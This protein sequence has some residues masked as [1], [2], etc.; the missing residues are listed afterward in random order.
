MDLSIII[1]N[2]N[3]RDFLLKCVQSVF[4]STDNLLYEVIVV[5]NASSDGSQA[6]IRGRFPQVRMIENVENVGFVR[7]NNQA[8]STCRGRYVLLLNSDAEAT[9]GSLSELVYFMDRHPAAAVVGPRLVNPDFS[10]QASHTPFPNLTQEFL[11]LSSIGRRLVRPTYPS[12]GPQIEKGPQMTDYVEGACLLVRR[13]A[14]D[15]VG[16]LDERIFMYTEEVDWCYRFV[17][18][19]WQVWYIPHAEVI[20]HGG[21]STKMRPGTMEAQL[22]RSRVYFFKKHY[23]H[24]SAWLLKILVYTLTLSKIV[25]NGILRNLTDG[26]RGRTVPSLRQLHAAMRL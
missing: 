21:Q 8:M 2:W 17:Q 12:F 14:M 26:S 18:A 16:K 13:D 15:R 22:Y 5:D 11:K 4:E 1:V 10:F 20:H 19:G 24:C 3:T 25:I 9:H 23:G 6:M 7:A